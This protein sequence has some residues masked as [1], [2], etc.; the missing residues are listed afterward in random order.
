MLQTSASLAGPAWI[1]RRDSVRFPADDAA[2][3]EVAGDPAFKLSGFL[4]DASRR[5]VRLALPERVSRGADVKII[6]RGAVVLHGE[7]RYCR[8][9]GTIYYAGV[10]IRSSGHHS[11]A[12]PMAPAHEGDPQEQGN[13]RTSLSKL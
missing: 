6:V 3:I 13:V 11:A 8:S 9:A 5:G 1:E 7:V 10:L 4:R 12:F 2:E